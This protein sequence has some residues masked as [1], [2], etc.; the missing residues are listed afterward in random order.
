M[1]RYSQG[2]SR[3]QIALHWVVVL[4]VAAQYIFNDAISGAWDAIRQ[5]QS[6][7]FDPLILAHVAGGSLI[8]ALVV[9]RLVLR[10]RHGAPSPPENEPAAL[11]TLSHV[12]HWGFYALLGAMAATGFL[13]WFGGVGAAAQAHNVLK[14]ALLALVGMHVLAV[15][16]HR[17]VLKNNVMQRMIRPAA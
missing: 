12:A 14:V 15:P 2:Y 8:L 1:M 5:G 3:T 16:F 17:I 13:A 4:L 10:L 9:W 7:A 11:A 6:Y